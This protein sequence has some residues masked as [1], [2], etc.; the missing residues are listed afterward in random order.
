MSTPLPSTV[1]AWLEKITCQHPREI[2]LG[3]ERIR[4]VHTRMVLPPP[5]RQ[6]ITLAGTN[7]KGSTAAFITAIARAAGWRV[8]AYT[9]PHLL[10]YNERVAIDGRP[11]DDAA[12]LAAFAAVEGARGETPL[13]YFEFGT[14][15]ALWVFAQ[16]PLDLAVLEVGL[17]GRLDAVNLVNA[18]VAVITTVDIDHQDWLGADREAIGREKVGIARAFR[19][20]ILGDEDPPSSVLAHA[21]AIGASAIRAGSD[22]LFGRTT[23]AHWYWRD[24]GCEL[25]LPLPALAAPVQLRN[26][27]VAIAAL[28]ALKRRIAKAAFAAG[29]GAASL[30]GRLQ[31]FQRDGIEILLDVGHNPQ[32]AAALAQYL[33]ARGGRIHAVYAPLADKDVVGVVDAL[34]AEV[35][36]WHLAGSLGAGERGQSGAALAARLVASAAATGRVHADV[37][38]P[39]RAALDTAAPGEGILVFGSFYA[40]AEALRLLS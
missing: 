25:R 8:G 39:L 19:P 38:A 27:A 28:R 32:A 11:V 5:A 3:L 34:R 13:T 18:D 17:G 10:R 16:H 33:R 4:P 21:Y 6:V 31:A 26:A 22:F 30:P 1:A 14:L 15:A 20:L 36:H 37:A 2:E 12:L 35:D 7:G 29:V 23:D 9:S 40:A 24:P